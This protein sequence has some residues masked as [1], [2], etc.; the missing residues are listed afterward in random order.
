MFDLG[1]INTVSDASTSLSA[2]GKTVCVCPDT[3]D[4]AAS[5][6]TRRAMHFMSRATFNRKCG[7]GKP[8]PTGWLIYTSV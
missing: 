1:H 5:A 7:R 2:M 3:T 6:A 8:V 4:E